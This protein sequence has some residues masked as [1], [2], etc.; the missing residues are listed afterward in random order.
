MDFY[1][2][3]NEQEKMVENY[4]GLNVNLLRIPINGI[5]YR[6]RGDT[7]RVGRIIVGTKKNGKYF[8]L[9]SI[10]S[11]NIGMLKTNG[12]KSKLCFF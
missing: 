12:F 7:V 4:L 9:S 10:N 3:T 8:A 6:E 1:I 5:S 11:V 2:W